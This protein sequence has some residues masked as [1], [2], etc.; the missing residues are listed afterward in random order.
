MQ[1]WESR[2]SFNSVDY[3]LN[4]IDWLIDWLI[5]I[6]HGP[7][8]HSASL[9]LDLQFY[10][11]KICN[12]I[13]YFW[14]T[15][16]LGACHILLDLLQTAGYL[17]AF[18]VSIYSG[19]IWAADVLWALYEFQMKCSDF[20]FSSLSCYCIF[21]FFLLRWCNQ[22]SNINWPIYWQYLCSGMNRFLQEIWSSIF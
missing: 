1:S 14:I 19:Y 8:K 10:L 9:P 17:Y 3:V 11:P 16:L 5:D 22:S 12:C 18:F 4:L 7:L 20:Q 13:Y 6:S 21:N 2:G 15:V